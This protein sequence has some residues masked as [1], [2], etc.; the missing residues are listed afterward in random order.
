[1]SLLSQNGSGIR[2]LYEGPAADLVDAYLGTLRTGD[3]IRD[4]DNVYRIIHK[5]E[6]VDRAPRP[7]RKTWF[8][9]ARDLVVEQ[10]AVEEE[11][12]TIDEAVAEVVAFI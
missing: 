11:N 6:T 8:Q 7:T 2:P 5:G 4:A 1:M 9:M 3:P 12:L 10:A